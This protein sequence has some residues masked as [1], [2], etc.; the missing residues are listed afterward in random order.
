MSTKTEPD[1]LY[2]IAR[3]AAFA[4]SSSR[5]GVELDDLVHEGVLWLLENPGL[6]RNAEIPGGG[7][8]VP[9]LVA[10]IQ[11]HLIG[12]MK[13]NDLALYGP[14][15]DHVRWTPGVVRRALSY[16]WDT[17][18]PQP[19]QHEVHTQS[20][21]SHGM[22]WLVAKIDLRAA[23]DTEL[24]ETERA[25]L[26]RKYFQGDSWESLE[27]LLGEPAGTLSWRASESIGRLCESLNGR[28][29]QE[30]APGRSLGG[31]PGSRAVV[32]NAQARAIQ[33][34]YSND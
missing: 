18:P 24:S 22:G 1:T 31:G 20:D 27:A 25:L 16:V 34:S 13:A 4:V 14:D 12:S 21:P 6:M 19:E 32:S 10:R 28:I 23:L 5:A 30:P 17:E 3:K 26:F 11:R 8:N 33:E 7:Y 29:P 2:D 15:D 9:R